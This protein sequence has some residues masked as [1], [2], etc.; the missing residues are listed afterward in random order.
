MHA[1]TEQ[2]LSLREGH[3]VDAAVVVH[4]DGCED[5]RRAL[6]DLRRMQAR[7]RDLPPLEPPADLWRTV[8]V[9][10]LPQPRRE[11]RR[12]PLLVGTAAG[13]ALGMVLILNMTQHH[14]PGPAPGTTTDIVAAT[15]APASSVNGATTAEL[16]ATSQRLE[17]ALY[18]LPAAPRTTRASTALTIEELQDRIFEVDLLLNEPGLS[19]A[20]ERTLWQQ[21]VRLMDTLMQVRLAQLSESR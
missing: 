10:T 19:Q 20:D 13:F 8:A 2:L 12:W 1:T 17:A 15:P 5:C 18:A 11:R 7:L 9:E 3:P 16:L 14:D 4:V 6:R 21:R